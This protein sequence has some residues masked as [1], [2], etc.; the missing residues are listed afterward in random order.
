MQITDHGL[1]FKMHSVQKQN[2]KKQKH[3]ET[4]G[5]KESVH[6]VVVKAWNGIYAENNILLD[7]F[8]GADDD[9]AWRAFHP[10]SSYPTI[11]TTKY[12]VRIFFVRYSV[13]VKQKQLFAQT[14][15]GYMKIRAAAPFFFFFFFS[16]VGTLKAYST[17][18]A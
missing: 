10:S 4:E 15:D 13:F 14:N 5:L 1:G 8:E 9:T 12:K 16:R 11:K 3:I 18:R 17:L 6:K 7:M 2:N